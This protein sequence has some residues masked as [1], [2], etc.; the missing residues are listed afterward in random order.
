M[1]TLK[2]LD[3]TGLGTLVAKIKA[4]IATA[5]SEAVDDADVQLV[6]TPEIVRITASSEAQVVFV[7]ADLYDKGERVKPSQWGAINGDSSSVL[8]TGITWKYETGSFWEASESY[9]G[10]PRSGYMLLVPAGATADMVE[11]SFYVTYKERKYYGHFYV[12]TNS[13]SEGGSADTSSSGDGDLANAEAI[14]DTEIAGL[15]S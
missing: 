4:A 7:Y 8:G 1:A 12:T 6:V 15:F 11:A 2:F 10:K 13:G 14:T 3:Y 5:K 9:D